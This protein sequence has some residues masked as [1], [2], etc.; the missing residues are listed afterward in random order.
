VAAPA[1]QKSHFFFPF[2]VFFFVV[3]GLA[4]EMAQG[5]LKL[6]GRVLLPEQVFLRGW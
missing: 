2:E 5:S 3:F 4:V 6:F 1:G